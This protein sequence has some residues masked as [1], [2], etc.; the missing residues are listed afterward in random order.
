MHSLRSYTSFFFMPTLG[1]SRFKNIIW[2][3]WFSVFGIVVM[4][5]GI[6]SF[7]TALKITGLS[8]SI[9]IFVY[10]LNDA[11]DSEFDKLNI[12]KANRPIPS[13]IATKYHALQLSLL[14]GII[15][16]SI[17]ITINT[18]V[19]LFTLIYMVLGFAYSVP[20]IQLKRRFLMKDITIALALFLA[21]AIGALS[22]GYIAPSI[23][24]V[25]TY[26]II[27]SMTVSPTFYEALDEKEDRLYGCKTI[28]LLLKQSRRLELATLGLLAMMVTTPLTYRNFGFNMIFPI[29]VCLSCLLFLR[30]VFPLTLTRDNLTQKEMSKGSKYMQIFALIV[31]F[32]ILFGSLNIL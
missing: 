9:A 6:P 10:L 7:I 22:S 32:A 8:S 31:Q 19:L 11:M 2:T 23:I 13:G 24:Y 18:L 30:Y 29:L 20:P 26:F 16:I 12:T 27:I 14:G 1:D 15:G 4:N 5:H 28:S 17:A 3:A 25:S 21:I